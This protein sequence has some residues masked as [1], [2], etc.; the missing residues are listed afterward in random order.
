MLFG[1]SCALCDWASV[2]RTGRVHNCKCA[3]VYLTF[4][5]TDVRI[6]HHFY[7]KNSNSACFACV[8]DAFNVLQQC[9]VPPYTPIMC[10]VLICRHTHHQYKYT[11]SLEQHP[12]LTLYPVVSIYLVL[13]SLMML[14][15]WLLLRALTI[16]LFLYL[17]LHDASASVQ[18]NLASPCMGNRPREAATRLKIEFQVEYRA[19]PSPLFSLC[20][21]EQQIFSLHS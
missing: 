13:S 9:N 6:N 12:L 18:L 20:I 15:P 11:C 2:A 1:L 21:A 14:H 7:R 19:I 10:T 4:C 5:V 8:N 17:F 3:N 16:N